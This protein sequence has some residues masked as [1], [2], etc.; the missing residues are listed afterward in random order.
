MTEV[1]VLTRS[2]L[3]APA[4][5]APRLVIADWYEEYGDKDRADFIRIQ[6]EIARLEPSVIKRVGN[7]HV[8]RDFFRLSSLREKEEAIL[9]PSVI[10][11]RSRFKWLGFSY[12]AGLGVR[13]HRG[14][15]DK[16]ALPFDAFWRNATK[17]FS[18]QP[19][20]QVA[21]SD[22]W[23]K[24]FSCGRWGLSAYPDRFFPKGREPSVVSHDALPDSIC[25]E[26]GTAGWN[27]WY[28]PKNARTAMN[29][30]LVK[31][32]RQKVGLAKLEGPRVMCCQCDHIIRNKQRCWVCKGKGQV[33]L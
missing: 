22:K 17:Y 6:C 3:E 25:D 5:D 19:I 33:Q 18:K 12:T 13:F 7:A 26:I 21:L 10:P 30:G 15:V 11:A 31:F 2:V 1:Q 8:D 32:G 23:P 28:S 14:F 4:D 27:S 9:G 24:Q 16:I 29:W 20:T